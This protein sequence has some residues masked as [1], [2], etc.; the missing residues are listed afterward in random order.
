MQTEVSYE[1]KQ[2]QWRGLVDYK[3]VKAPSSF[4]AESDE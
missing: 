3:F 4:I 2:N 1:R